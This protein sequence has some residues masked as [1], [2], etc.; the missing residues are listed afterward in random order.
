[1]DNTGY[2]TREN[3]KQVLGDDYDEARVEAMIAEADI[4]VRGKG[5]QPFR[6]L[7]SA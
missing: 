3:M 4:M 7:P 2:I 6:V 1:M 5:P